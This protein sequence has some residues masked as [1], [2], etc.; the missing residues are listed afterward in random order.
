MSDSL[1]SPVRETEI[2]KDTIIHD[3]QSGDD[4]PYRYIYYT[5]NTIKKRGYSITIFQ[6]LSEKDTFA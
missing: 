4:L 1:N 6:V 5:G 3:D 2:I